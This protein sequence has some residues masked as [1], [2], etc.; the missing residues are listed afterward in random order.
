MECAAAAGC[1]ETRL[2]PAYLPPHRPPPV[3]TPGQRLRMVELAV[4][5]EAGLRVDAVEVRRN[6][7]SYSVDTL[8]GLRG[9]AGSD[10]LCLIIGHDAFL[11]LHTW[12]AWDRL[13]DY[14]HLV[15]ASRPGAE[16]DE[17]VPALRELER[18]HGA[19]DAA[20]LRA[21]PAG[22]V[23]RVTI[24]ALDISSS[25]IR[26]MIGAGRSVRYLVPD[27]VMQF[28]HEEALYRTSR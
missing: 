16:S 18:R 22:C 21:G 1:T 24:P 20:A 15:V 5:G 14:A 17:M 4:R 19:A 28:I 25:R 2:I 9:S 7:T 26:R 6:G 10:P 12:R 27:A 23:L 11:E 3:A 13:L 8:A